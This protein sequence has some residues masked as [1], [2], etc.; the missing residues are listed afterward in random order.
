M[1]DASS[2]PLRLA[3]S[4]YRALEAQAAKEGRTPSVVVRGLIRAY[5]ASCGSTPTVLADPR[6]CCL[7]YED[8]DA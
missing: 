2:P 3:M 5:L 8:S 4:D 6:Q 7:S 1:A